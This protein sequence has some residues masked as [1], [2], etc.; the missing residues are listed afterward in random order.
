MNKKVTKIINKWDP[1]N[2]FP[3]APD[4]EY[5]YEIKKIVDFVKSNPSVTSE[6]LAAWINQ[7]F[8]N[9]FGKDIY[10]CDLSVVSEVSRAILQEV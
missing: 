5:K 8:E 3:M 10:R 2:L 9:Q 7:L 6:Q 1:M 4:N